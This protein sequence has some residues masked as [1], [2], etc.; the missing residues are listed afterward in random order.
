MKPTI[1]LSSIFLSAAALV[2]ADIQTFEGDGFGAWQTEGKA[3]GL[4][5]VHEKLDGMEKPFTNFA[6]DAFALSAHGGYDAV[7]T[8]TSPEIK[9]QSDYLMFL[10]AGGDNPAKLAV[11][12]IIDGNVVMETTGKKSQNFSN[13]VWDIKKFKGKNALIRIVDDAK[14][15]WGYIAVD[16]FMQ[17]NYAN[18]KFPPSTKKGKPYAEGLVTSPVLAGAMIP[19]ETS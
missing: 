17:E 12:L 5:P 7:G 8:L 2:F 18:S 14:G 9:I 11:Q 1:L 3:F 16:H 15:E 19:K 13:V 6:N 10:V 4:S